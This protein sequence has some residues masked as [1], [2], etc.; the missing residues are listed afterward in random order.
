ME[1]YIHIPFCV[2]KCNYCDFLSY[3][4]YGCGADERHRSLSCNYTEA[5]CGELKEI[6]SSHITIDTC[7]IGGGTPSVLSDAE[8]EKLLQAVTGLI[9]E[10]LQEFT[11]ECNPGTLTREKL[12]IYKK[13]G[14]N[15]ISMGLQSAD[16]AILSVLGRIHSFEQ[17]Q[18]NFELAR[19]LG[20]N[21]INVDLISGVPGQTLENW[22]DTL[23]K[24]T[25]LSPEH[26]SAYSLILEEGTPLYDA[27]L[28]DPVGL[29]LPDEDTER[30]I[31]HYTL[32]YLQEKGYQ[33]YEISNYV[34]PGYEC[35]HNIGYWTGE[36]YIGAG[37]GASS[38]LNKKNAWE[39][40]HLSDH[41]SDMGIKE[42]TRGK[43]DNT[44]DIM[45]RIKNTE[46]IDEYIDSFTDKSADNRTDNI[47]NGIIDSVTEN[48]TDNVTNKI[49]DKNCQKIYKI[50]EILDTDAL[51]SEYCILG[52][53]MTEGVSENGF[54]IKFG[55][56]LNEKF[57]EI[58]DKYINAGLL[59]RK[60]DRIRF[61]EKG[62]DLSNTVLCEFL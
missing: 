38:Y 45:F 34:R 13:D 1:L 12:L 22:K 2:R 37:L 21:N 41:S 10:K 6:G 9:S 51:M 3:P 11:I 39:I 4:G 26:I 46:D 23:E 7:F 29:K 55:R 20:F 58:I 54:M 35:R 49:I 42:N 43:S 17:F 31:Y 60:E 5:L 56:S 24:V 57:G 52:L 48:I 44:A 19:S 14:V 30:E 27:Y 33:R 25:A 28:K 59:E 15:R 50:E 32:K 61:T 18:E 40:K 62:Q 8:T 53:R 36:E 47:T 16:N